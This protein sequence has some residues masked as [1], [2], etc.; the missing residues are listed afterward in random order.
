V[1]DISVLEDGPLNS[2]GKIYPISRN[3]TTSNLHAGRFTA[4]CGVHIYR[5]DLLPEKYHGAAFTCDPTGNLIHCEM[6]TERGASFQS[7]PDREGVEF[8]ASPDDW[9]RPVSMAEGPDGALY[10]VDMY[11]A[12]IEHPEYMPPELRKRPDLMLGK[13]KGRI[14][15][16]VPEKHKTKALRPNLS[17]V[18]TEDLDD[19]FMSPNAW[20]RMT[21]HRLFLERADRPDPKSLAKILLGHADRNWRLHVVSLLEALGAAD[22]KTLVPIFFDEN[23]PRILEHAVRLAEPFLA[24]SERIR[25]CVFDLAKRGDAPLRFQVA[26]SLGEWDDDRILVPLAEIALRGAD[27][28]W[29]RLAVASSVPKRAGALIAVLLGS[30]K[31]LTTERSTGRLAL[32]REL[33]GLV[34]SRRDTKEVAE[35]LL[36]VTNLSGK[37]ATA[38]QLAALEGV[39]E[40]MSRRGAQLGAFLKSLPKES[41]KAADD[42]NALLSQFA[43]GASDRK[44]DLG[45]RVP[46]VRL[47]SHL[48]WEKAEPVLT[49]LLTDDP[50]QEVRLAAVRALAAHGRADVPGLLLKP[51]KGYTP[52]VRREVTEALLRQPDWALALLKEVEADRIKPGDIDAPRATLLLAHG[53][54]DVRNLARK[55]LQDSLPAERQQVLA[56]YQAALKRKGDAKKGREVFKKN[57]A[58]CHR[59]ADI[60]VDV[61]PDISDT[62]TKT[63]EMLLGDILNPNQAID[64]NYINYLVTTKSG[65]SLTGMIAAETAASITLKRAENQTDVVLRQDIEE[66]TST[67]ASLMPEGL[68]KTISIEE[69]ADLLSFLKNWRYLDGAVPPLDR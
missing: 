57:C 68:E 48:P 21:A 44:R 41:R 65:K 12:V 23:E 67:G 22:E 50:A 59:V 42:T 14:W 49:R 7:K 11:R 36:T 61:G 13:D 3:W 31:G 26:L 51:W 5:S 4:A 16:I 15:R 8:L 32:L 47:L 25:K 35:L 60:G 55:L 39:A 53:R 58:T 19:H 54:A 6:L 52:A 45:E 1:Q 2:G 40:G 9:F 38:W 46:A 62:R 24:R 63:A 30:K 20:E 33:A 29:T 10:V 17:K 18:K 34:G 56:R 43:S 27:D 37:D 64:N 28:R 69:M 66:I